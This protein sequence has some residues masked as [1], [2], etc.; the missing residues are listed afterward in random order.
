MDC[1]INGLHSPLASASPLQGMTDSSSQA[2]KRSST[3]AVKQSSSQAVMQS[4][5]Q[6]VKQKQSCSRAI[7]QPSSQA[8]SLNHTRQ[9]I[10]T[11]QARTIQPGAL[12]GGQRAETMDKRHQQDG[13]R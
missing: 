4:S 2:V 10:S 9:Q 7:K 11:N 12:G 5:N 6:A 3:Q 8:D 13:R 1:P